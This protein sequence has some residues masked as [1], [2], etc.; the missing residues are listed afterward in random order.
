MWSTQT[1]PI[2]AVSISGR[3]GTQASSGSTSPA[4]A[5][6][7]V[8]HESAS[9]KTSKGLAEPLNKSATGSAPANW[10]AGLAEP[11]KSAYKGLGDPLKQLM[12][13]LNQKNQYLRH[14]CPALAI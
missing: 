11:D 13:S 2:K 1:N 12:A 5:D 10:G 14:G 8:L 9:E 6:V 3:P 4:S 7:R